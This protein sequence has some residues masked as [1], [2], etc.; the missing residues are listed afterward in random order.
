M[1]LV[2]FLFGVYY[3]VILDLVQGVL[4]VFLVGMVGMVIMGLAAAV[5]VV[6]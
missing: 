4:I 3:V 1:G 6:E 2:D 5:V